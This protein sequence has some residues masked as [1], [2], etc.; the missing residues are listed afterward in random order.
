MFFFVS[1]LR[2]AIDDDLPKTWSL[3]WMVLSYILHD[4]CFAFNASGWMALGCVPLRVNTTRESESSHQF[5]WQMYIHNDSVYPLI[6]DIYSQSK[7][8]YKLIC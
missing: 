7:F 2:K 3:Y 1:M 8:L 6:A 5:I 4:M